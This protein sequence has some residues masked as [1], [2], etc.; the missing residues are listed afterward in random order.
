[1]QIIKREREREK[2]SPTPLDDGG[3]F[4][5]FDFITK[6]SP[7]SELS[8]SEVSGVSGLR[9]CGVAS[10]VPTSHADACRFGIARDPE[11]NL[12]ISLTF[13]GTSFHHE[14]VSVIHL[15]YSVPFANFLSTLHTVL[16]TPVTHQLAFTEL[17]L[18]RLFRDSASLF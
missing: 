5:Q 13:H 7:F 4:N 12:S 3:L 11:H 6:S 8:E 16:P 2:K 10:C 1:M 18:G 15:L 9:G 17:Q 14:P